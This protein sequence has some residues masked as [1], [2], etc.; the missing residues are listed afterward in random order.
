VV[1]ELIRQWVGSV[2]FGLNQTTD[3]WASAVIKGEL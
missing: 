1:F 2:V 3:H